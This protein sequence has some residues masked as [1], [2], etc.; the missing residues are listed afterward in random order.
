MPGRGS[1][2]Y[3]GYTGM[4]ERTKHGRWKAAGLGGG[5]TL[6]EVMVALLVLSIGLLGLAALQTAALRDG[7]RAELRTR[8]VQAASDMVERMRANPAGTAAGRYDLPRNRTP[9]STGATGAAL[10][11]LLAWRAGLARLP[12]GQGGITRCS[13]GCPGGAAAVRSVTVWWNAARDPAVH[14]H[15]CPPRTTADLR[16]VRLVLR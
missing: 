2:S 12:G 5:F 15:R 11:D 1:G 10:T 7:Q 4:R 13:A 6:I 16:C 14:G 3:L 9:R 8:A